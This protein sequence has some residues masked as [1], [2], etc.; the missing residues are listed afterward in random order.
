[1]EKRYHAGKCAI[2]TRADGKPMIVGY[3]AVFYRADNPGT[4]YG[5]WNGAY[6]RVAPG[7]FRSTLGRGD[8]VRGLFNHDPNHIYGRTESGT[9]RLVVDDVG[10]RYEIDPPETEDGR[11]LVDKIRRKDVTGSSF[12]FTVN[13]E[14]WQQRDD[15]TEIRTLED[16]TLYDVGPVTFPAYEASSTAV[17]SASDCDSARAS[18]AAWQRNKREARLRELRLA[19]IQ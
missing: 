16:V 7:A 18:Y 19:E 9:M 12:S 2:E 17:R 1:M 11:S 8:D 15:G 3:G 10:L 4:Q 14:S 13:K 5:I 6:E